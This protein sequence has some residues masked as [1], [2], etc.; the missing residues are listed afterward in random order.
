MQDLGDY[1]KSLEKEKKDLTKQIQ[2]TEK[3]KVFLE[4]IGFPILSFSKQENKL[5]L[6]TPD[7]SQM[8]ECDVV[9]LK[10]GIEIIPSEERGKGYKPEEFYTKGF[11][12]SAKKQIGNFALEILLKD[13]D[14][15]KRKMNVLYEYNSNSGISFPNSY[16]KLLDF[17]K[18]NNLKPSVI[19][20]L[21]NIIKMSE[22]LIK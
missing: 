5:N 18:S 22:V 20:K 13:E 1:I 12:F 19:A 11:Q 10:R 3:L 9:N 6:R 16:E 4:H 17:Y 8:L 21:K 14:A 7:Y 2:D 15:E